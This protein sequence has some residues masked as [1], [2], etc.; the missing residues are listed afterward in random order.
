MDVVTKMILDHILHDPFLQGALMKVA[1]DAIHTWLKGVDTSGTLKKEPWLEPAAIVAAF[2]A[3]ALALA[4]QGNLQNI[5]LSTISNLLISFLGA[6]VVGTAT[7]SA[8]VIKVKN[9]LV[10][11]K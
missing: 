7:I 11:T 2:L 9:S 6:K 4:A 5:D 10:P 3:Q 8:A 1:T